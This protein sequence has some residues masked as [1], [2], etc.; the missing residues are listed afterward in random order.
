MCFVEMRWKNLQVAVESG[1]R[2]AGS[3]RDLSFLAVV[4]GMLW[5]QSDHGKLHLERGIDLLSHHPSM[6]EDHSGASGGE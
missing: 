6:I 3:S 5:E 1:K 2:T 4:A